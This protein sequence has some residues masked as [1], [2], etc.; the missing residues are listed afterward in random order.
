[1]PPEADGVDLTGVLTRGEP[2]PRLEMPYYHRGQL[3]AYRQGRYKLQFYEDGG[4]RKKRER[5]ALFDLHQDLGERLD[6][7]D[8]HPDIVETIMAAVSAHQ[9]GVER[10]API[11]DLRLDGKGGPPANR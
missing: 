6:I 1:L 8:Q 3:T 11:F 7:A 10:V 9:A 4:F 5:P 2:G